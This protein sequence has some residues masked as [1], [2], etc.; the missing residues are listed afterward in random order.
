[1]AQIPSRS[2]DVT[3]LQQALASG[4]T[5][6]EA[7][8]EQS[9]VLAAQPAAAHVFT[10]L[11][12]ESALASARHADA[13][14]RSG[15][16]LGRLAGLPVTIKDL[17]DV[18]G[19]TTTSGSVVCA[20]EAPAECDAPPVAR[21]RASGAA[22]LGKTNMSEF[23]FSG[24]G[25]NPH[26]GTPANPADAA[27]ARIPGGSSSGAAVSV[28]LGMALAGLGSDTGGSLRIPAALCGLVGFKG[29]QA[30]VTRQ[31]A[32]EL[33]R[34][35]DTVGAITRSVDDAWLLDAVLSGQAL[36]VRQR[37]VKGLRLAVPTTL[38][39]DELDAEVSKAF[40]HTL[41]RLSAAGA[42]I[43]EVAWSEL[44][45]IATLNAPGGFSP[46]E[47]YAAHRHRL[48]ADGARFD[49]RVAQ[50]MAL[51]QGVSAADYLTMI[52]QRQAWIGRSNAAMQGFDAVICPT[53]PMVAPAIDATC[54]SDAP[55]FAAN[56][57]LLRNTFAINY[58]D[59]CAISLP[60]QAPGDLPVGLMLARANGDDAE[61]LGV[62]KAIEAA[63]A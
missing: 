31:G 60:C 35:L 8:V 41:G 2:T 24:V 61:L 18:A 14:R 47:A 17:F 25:Y 21:L 49:Q 19:E 56:R 20:S 44:S 26:W 30:R 39:Q 45:E 13:Q 9:L 15:V 42:L 50:R 37:S 16:R 28:G 23:A 55:F 43:E 1:M 58:W 10:H 51:G 53:V 12:A 5:T 34:S 33:A 27:V 63:L 62:A 29:S 59:G 11:W 48:A 22:L 4:Q 7:W 36:S 3:R 6:C 32:M 54:A 46:V 38:M 57:L 40:A 52:D